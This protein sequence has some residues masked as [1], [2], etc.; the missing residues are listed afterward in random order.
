MT[1]NKDT[2]QK[3]LLGIIDK[4][5]DNIQETSNTNTEA[6]KSIDISLSKLTEYIPSMD[7]VAELTSKVKEDATEIRKEVFEISIKVKI[8]Y[9]TI[10]ILT[11]IGIAF[12]GLYASQYKDD[13][14]NGVTTSV[15]K[16]FDDHIKKI[17]NDI[18]IFEDRKKQ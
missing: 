17:E 14:I 15:E 13:I 1:D 4:M 9:A 18:K 10:G 12:L 3:T 2:N 5:V 16:L 6:L 7:D 8:L 11:S